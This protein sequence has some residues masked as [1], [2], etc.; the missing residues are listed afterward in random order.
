MDLPDFL[1]Q[2]YKDWKENNFPSENDL[3]K[4]LANEG[5]KPKAMII[6]CCDSRV[7]ANKIFNTNV[8]EF[9]IHRN[10]ANL[11][12]SINK[13]ETNCE[14]LS[15]IEYALKSLKIPNIIILGHSGCGGINF[16]YR[17]FSKK[18][19]QNSFLDKW[20]EIVEPAYKKTHKTNLN[21]EDE[22]IS[23]L[24][25]NSII[26]SIC[27][28]E[29]YPF[30]NDLILKNRLHIYGLWFD[31]GSGNIEYLNR[32]NNKFEKLNYL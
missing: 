25:K 8:G 17:K 16:A 20:I 18:N 4:S 31:I 21:N 28:L 24:E 23:L 3:F 11:V 12:P 27:N 30:V 2:R 14:T 29:N 32:Q 13:N 26:N 10:V 9:F 5:Q 19:N 7:D 6:S 1:I 15:S 22:K